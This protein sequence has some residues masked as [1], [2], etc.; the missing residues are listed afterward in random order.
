MVR[1]GR[2][3]AISPVLATVVLIAMTLISAI[4][5]SGFVFG[6]FGNFTSSAQV[7]AQLASCGKSGNACPPTLYNSGSGNAAIYNGASCATLTYL[8][9]T[10]KATSCTGG[11]G[12]TV[13]GGSSLTVTLTSHPISTRAPAF[14]S[15]GASH[16]ITAPKHCSLERSH[17][18]LLPNSLIQTS[19]GLSDQQIN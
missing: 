3:K 17:R 8:G 18:P 13:V 5:V 12:S 2:R 16:S 14:S 15:R 10:V 6:L 9:Q 4:S 7:Q 11:S 1:F 19:S